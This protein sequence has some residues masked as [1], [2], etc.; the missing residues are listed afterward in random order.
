[1]NLLRVVAALCTA[2][3]LTASAWE[4]IPPFTDRA[5]MHWR[6]SLETETDCATLYIATSDTLKPRV[7]SAR[8]TVDGRHDLM[9]LSTVRVTLPDSSHIEFKTNGDKSGVSYRLVAFDA[10]RYRL[11]IGGNKVVYSEV[12][13]THGAPLYISRRADPR[14]Q[15]R[16]DMAFTENPGVYPSRFDN[17]DDLQREISAASNPISGIWVHYD[18]QSPD[19]TVSRKTRYTLAVVPHD[20]DTLDLILVQADGKLDPRWKPFCLKGRLK[21]TSLDGIY[22][23]EWYD[24]RGR[25]ADPDATAQLTADNVLTVRLPSWKTTIVYIKSIK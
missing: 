3:A 22:N 9:G 5:R 11:E 7:Y 1:M 8:K 10:D 25:N 16:Y 24:M 21:R 18:Q 2:L 4:R 19:L 6:T 12:I 14:L 23:L 13:D 15:L 17:M 20:D